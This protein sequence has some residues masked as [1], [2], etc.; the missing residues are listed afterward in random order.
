MKAFKYYSPVAMHVGRHCIEHSSELLSAYGERAFIITSRFAPG[1]KNLALDDM[2]AVLRSLGKEYRLWDSVEENPSVE[3]IRRVADAII[4]FA[5]D[6][7]IAVGGGSALD[8]AKAANI[9]I[10]YPK[11]ADAFQVFYDGEPENEP[12]Q[13]LGKLRLLGIPTTAGSGAE[14]AGYAVLTRNDIGTKQRMNQLSFFTDAFLDSRYIEKSPQWL[15]DAGAMDALTHGI[16]GYFNV[17]NNFSSNMLADIGFKLFAIY[18]EH[19]LNGGLTEEDYDNMLLAASIQGMVV[20]LS[21]TTLP[22]GMSYALTHEKGLTHGLAVAVYQAEY[23][24]VFKR[25]ENLEKIAH[26]LKLTGFESIDA[27][28]D[29]LAQIVMRNVTLHVSAA[30]LSAWVDAFSV[31]TARLKRH[32]EP[33]SREEIARVYTR[34]LE[35]TGALDRE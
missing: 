33:I 9:L 28:G 11:G 10:K 14:M 30:E 32:P 18:R 29:Y 3:S 16:E 6:Y 13:A 7:I 12:S 31:N 20:V 27:L 21:S 2:C 22:H 17:S 35:R 19:L 34:S 4:D 5:P 8:T 23:L 1:F 15:I 26:I 24:K 25:P